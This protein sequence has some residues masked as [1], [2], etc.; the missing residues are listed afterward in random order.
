MPSNSNL[1]LSKSF[2]N[3]NNLKNTKLKKWVFQDFIHG[4]AI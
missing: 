2:I 1:Y 4:M 3:K